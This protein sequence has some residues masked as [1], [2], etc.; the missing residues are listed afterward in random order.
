MKTKVMALGAA[1]ALLA[2][3]AVAERGT[4]GQVNILFWQAVS[5]MNPYLSGGI[6]ELHAAALVLEPMARY[7]E[8]GTMMP[9]LAEA[10]P[11]VENGG[12][13]EDLTQ[14]TWT[15]K[16]GLL[17]SDGTP[18]T[19]EDAVF[20]AEYCMNEEMGCAYVAR[21]ND[22]E[23][24]A[25]VDD[26]TV[27]ITFSVPTPFPYGPFVGGQSPIIQKAQF[28]GCT[29]AAAAGCTAQNFGPIGTG[30]YRV[31]DFRANDVVLYEINEHYR[32]PEKPAFASV[33]IKGGGDAAS[34][35]RAVL[36]TGEFDYAWN[37]QIEP[38]VLSQM[39]AAGRGE[40]LV[41]FGSLIERILLNPTDPDPSHGALR[42][43]LDAGPHPYLADPVVGRAMSL[44]LD[45]DII[46]ELGYGAAG[47]PTCNIVAAPE[48]Y[49]SPNTGWCMAQD[50]GE[51][52]RL[53]D[54]AGYEMGPDGVRVTP[55]G[56]RM[57]V[58]YQTS[59]NSVRQGT[60]ALVKQMWAEIG[61]E[62]ELR[63]IDAGV[64]FGGDP[65]SPD[66]FQ[67]FYADVQEYANRFEGTDPA[68]Y[69]EGFTCD[70]IP[71]P[72]N[73]W[74]GPNDARTC[75]EAYDALAVELAGTP[76]IEARAK[77]VVEMNDM[78]IESGTVVPIVHR[79]DVSARSLTLD[80][81]R[82]TSFDS[83]FWNIADWR[84]A[85]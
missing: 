29:G 21:F 71:S 81:V 5:T 22:V 70:A 20:T 11:T 4:D 17:W 69:M 66:T 27:R 13:S 67:K 44:A 26:R 72:A 46:V 8:T 80:G 38:E 30:P 6:K 54:E 63:N 19:A 41:S 3:T 75:I 73:N 51:A 12:V 64:F 61:I 76:G 79:G 36:E 10:I 65:A 24:V 60:Q 56:E 7:D 14:I 62:A 1:T 68:A 34:A 55:D 85:E 84:R 37:L 31:S 52:N 33:Q 58:L 32:D 43:T 74:N 59:T 49:D 53:L 82:M 40:L 25:A 35:A 78:L 15:L 28:E 48:I 47:R 83:E 16:E 42:S 77:I 39:E 2:S 57:T 23:S 18:V 45:R 50:I 9:Y